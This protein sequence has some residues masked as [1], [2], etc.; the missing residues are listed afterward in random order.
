MKPVIG[1]TGGVGSGK[2][3]VARQL[4]ALGCAVIDAD[5]LALQALNHPDVR[6]QVVQWWGPQ[7]IAD[8][9]TVD[10]RS[11]GQIVFRDPSQLQRLEGLIHPRVRES[12]GRM[13]AR[14]Q[15]DPSCVAIVEDCPLLIEKK[16]D[17]DCDVVLFVNSSLENRLERVKTHRAWSAD[18]LARREKS[19]LPLDIKA[20][21]A[22][23]VID[24][25]AGEDECLSH[26]RRVFSQIL[27][28]QATSAAGGS[29]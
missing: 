21:Q 10:R 11:V 16:I 4:A 26:V 29:L 15:S 28:D 25:N 5:Q 23:Y 1:L 19:Q 6:D 13:R 24:N 2:S 14:Y 12:R 20:Q 7:V 8:D 3:L 9:G 17:Q 27:P 18:E 22:D